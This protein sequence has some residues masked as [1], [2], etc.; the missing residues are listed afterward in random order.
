MVCTA[1]VSNPD[2]K[3][4]YDIIFCDSILQQPIQGTKKTWCPLNPKYELEWDTSKDVNFIFLNYI[5]LLDGMFY[6]SLNVLK[7]IWAPW[8][9]HQKNIYYLFFTVSC[10]INIISTIILKLF[11]RNLMIYWI[12]GHCNKSHIINIYY[13]SS[14]CHI[15]HQFFYENEKTMRAFV[16]VLKK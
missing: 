7:S 9:Q 15:N 3:W 13:R 16:L 10:Y 4:K 1:Y 5:S 11:L 2:G 14:D 8:V 12:W 6:F